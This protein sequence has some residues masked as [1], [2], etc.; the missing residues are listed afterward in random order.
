MA[1]SL[2]DVSCSEPVFLSIPKV[3][4]YRQKCLLVLQELFSFSLSPVLRL[5]GILPPSNTLSALDFLKE[6][7]LCPLCTSRSPTEVESL[8]PWCELEF[9]EQVRKWM[10]SCLDGLLRRHR[11]WRVRTRRSTNCWNST[12]SILELSTKC[13]VLQTSKVLLVGL[14]KVRTRRCASGWTGTRPDI[15][16]TSLHAAQSHAVQRKPPLHPKYLC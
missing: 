4:I 6:G 3:D 16:H 11:G 15:L 7:C 1:N 14:S 9:K 12:L 8:V 13:S 5:K 10:D 2:Q